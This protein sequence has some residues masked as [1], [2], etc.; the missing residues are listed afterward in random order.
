MGAF[1]CSS[2]MDAVARGTMSTGREVLE[3]PTAVAAE[4]STCHAKSPPLLAREKAVTSAFGGSIELHQRP[5]C[6]VSPFGPAEVSDGLPATYW[7][8]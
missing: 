6:E 4:L 8:Y 7:Y 2:Q 5:R 1:V 3:R